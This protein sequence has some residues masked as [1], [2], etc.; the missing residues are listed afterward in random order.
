MKVADSSVIEPKLAG[1][2]ATGEPGFR[3]GVEGVTSR[4]AISQALGV[5]WAKTSIDD[6]QNLDGYAVAYINIWSVTHVK[7]Y[8][9]L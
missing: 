7:I 1:D 4:P 5:L 9:C 2:G 3:A 6:V 8:N